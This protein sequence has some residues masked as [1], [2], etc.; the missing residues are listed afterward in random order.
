M[1]SIGY[2]DEDK[3]KNA[4]LLGRGTNAPM[5]IPLEP[6][7]P[8]PNSMLTVPKFD[9]SKPLPPTPQKLQPQ[10]DKPYYD[11]FHGRITPEILDEIR[12][13]HPDR[14]SGKTPSVPGK[15]QE[16]VTAP[17]VEKKPDEMNWSWMPQ[18]SKLLTGVFQSSMHQNPDQNLIKGF[19]ENSATLS[20]E[21]KTRDERRP[22]SDISKSYQMYAAKAMPGVDVSKMSAEAIK[23][24]I[25]GID[26]I[27]QN[28]L[29]NRKLDMEQVQNDKELALKQQALNTKAD[30]ESGP[31]DPNKLNSS[32]KTRYDN[33]Q[34][35]AESLPKMMEAIKSGTNTFSLGGDNA[36]TQQRDRMVEAFGRMQSGGAI[37]KDEEA[38]FAK[39]LPTWK[40]S[41]EIKAQKLND[42]AKLIED[43]MKTLGFDTR[44]PR[45]GQTVERQNI[46]PATMAQSKGVTFKHPKTGDT[47]T[48]SDPAKIEAFRKAGAVEL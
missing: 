47:V 15:N 28:N 4:L 33:L 14:V 16:Q 32:D 23:R 9:L 7:A 11:E 17:G 36:Y 2:T 42:A 5:S 8:I 1:A 6:S 19:D 40:D 44:M 12:K 37:N 21:Y 3:I 46:A 27:V 26:R 34:M 30:K 31:K 18:V 29:A 25:P 41:P 35:M 38:R 45:I 13:A 43:R 39:S 24:A 48:V 10:F 22:D 20:E